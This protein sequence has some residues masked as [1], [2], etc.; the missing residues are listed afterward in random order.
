MADEM[1]FDQKTEPASPRRREAAAEEGR[2]A[3]STE[4]NTGIV[5][6]IGVGGLAFLAHSLG[7]DLLQQMRIDLA[8]A[9]H[10]GFSPAQVE[11]QLSNVF[12]RGL[13]IVGL[14]LGM[15]FAAAIVTNVAQVGLRL[16]PARLSLDWDRVSPLHFSRILSWS[17]TMRG[18]MLLLKLAA[19]ATVAWWILRQRG[20]ELAHLGDA[21]LTAAVARSWRLVLRMALGLAS[22]LLA[23]GIVDYAWQRWHFE[24]SI[25]MTKQELKDEFKREEGDPQIKGRLRKMQR[26]NAQRKMFREVPKATVIVTNPTHLAVALQYEAGK[27]TAPKVIAKGADHV[28][29]RIIRLAR[30]Y[31]VPVVERKPLAQA[32]YKMVKVDREIPMGLY[33]V[34]AELLAHVYRLKSGT[35]KG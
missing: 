26:E 3:L 16:N 20:S 31:H 10:V 34:V 11:R 2:F 23:I 35:T 6:I 19:V 9:T 14:L 15:V 4:L 29:Q 18:L 28:A 8:G 5:M 7:S 1:D 32:L 12:S 22:T 27:M 30:R 13:T 33:L 25:R 24:R 21:D 17:K